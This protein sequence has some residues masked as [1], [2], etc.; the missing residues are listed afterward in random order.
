[1][2]DVQPPEQQRPEYLSEIWSIC[3]T[4]SDEAID[5]AESKAK[6]NQFNIDRGDV[7]FTEI[8]INLRSARNTLIDAIEKKK[9]IQLP[10][11]VQKELLSNLQA[12]GKALQGIM[13]S[14][15]EIVNFGSAVEVLNTS[16]W[17]YGLHNLS[18]QVLGYQAKL[19]QLKQQDVR[20]KNLLAIL[21]EGRTTSE[22]LAIMA[23]QAQEDAERIGKSRLLAEQEAST[24]STL[25]QQAE[26]ET[27]KVGNSAT[28][29]AQADAQIAQYSSAA[30]SAVANTAKITSEI[31]RWN[32]AAKNA[33]E[34]Q[35]LALSTEIESNRTAFAEQL[36]GFNKKLTLPSECVSLSQLV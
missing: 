11:T 31:D 9:L 1:M 27:T 12:I 7:T 23:R 8:S 16:I 17:K 15:D 10:I 24:A 21:E 28:S 36:V 22:N 25:R 19:N 34:V 20:A 6:A 35:A 2:E 29:A 4:L 30:K 3:T 14:A 26:E 33:S 5:A 32:S 18:E 13:N